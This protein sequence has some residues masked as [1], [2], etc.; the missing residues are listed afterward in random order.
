MTFCLFISENILT[1]AVKLKR[2][3]VTNFF[4]LLLSSSF[5][6]E[7]NKARRTTYNTNCV[8]LNLAT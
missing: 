8:D 3:F 7:H 4:L 5:L 2:N 1:H 6:H